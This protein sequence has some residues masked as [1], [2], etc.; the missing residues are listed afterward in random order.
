MEV[1]RVAV[2]FGG[3]SMAWIGILD[4]QCN[5]IKSIASFGKGA[6]YLEGLQ[7]PLDVDD[8]LGLGACASA[9]R[10]NRPIWYQ[11]F[12]H[13]PV[14]TQWQEHAARF[15]WVACASLPLHRNGAVAGVFTLYI[16][17]IGAF[18][19]K[20]RDL[21]EEM[22]S[23]IDFALQNFEREAKRVQTENDLRMSEK[24][25][26]TIL[27]M[28]SDG[29]HILDNSGLLVDAN[30]AFLNML[31]YD[32]SAIGKLRVTDWDVQTSSGGI[33][34]TFNNL[35]ANNNSQVLFETRHRRRDGTMLDIE[36]SATAMEIEG[37][38]YIYASSRD[39]SERKQLETEKE[40]YFKFFNTSTDLMCIAD[41][42]G[43]Y[44]K[45]NAAFIQTLGYSE[46]ELLSKPFNDSVH[47][48][49][50]QPTLDSMR[51]QRER[52]YTHD[53]E[54]RYRCKDGTYK[55]LSWSVG[56]D[57]DEGINYAVYAVAH[58]ITERKQAE[59]QLRKLSMAVEQSPESIVI[60][61]LNAEI[62]YVNDAFVKIT[63]YSR[64]ESIGQNPRFLSSG[65]TPPE[66]FK[67]L[68]DSLSKGLSWDG[69]FHN[70][71]K[72][73]SEYIEHAIITPIRQ[74]DESITHY[75][76]V[77]EDITDKKVASDMI[78]TL[79]FYDTLTGLPNRR[80][81]LDRLNHA[82][83]AGSRS[84]RIGALLFIDLDNFKTLNDTLGH[85][86][87]DLLL[88]QVAQRLTSCVREGDTVAR[89]GGDE[90]VVILEN[91]SEIS[92]EAT[93]QAE[94]VGEKIMAS[95]NQTYQL[96]N[97]H[98]RST[99]SIGIAFFSGQQQSVEDLLKQADLAMYQAKAAGR[100]TLSLF[101]PEMQ[102]LISSRA[103]LEEDLR[104]AVLKNQFVLHYQPQ[105]VGEGSLTGVEV[106]LRWRHP[107]RGM[108]SP[109]EFIPLAE[110]TG[111]ILPIGHWVLKTACNQLAKWADMPE[112]AHL[113]I[114]VNVSARQFGQPTFV[115]EVLA[116]ME[117]CGANPAKLK[118]ELTESILLNDVESVITKMSALKMK[119]VGFSLDD[120]GTG[121][122]SLSYLK[123]LPLDQLK[124]DRGFVRGT[125]TDPEDAAIA[126][127]VV[128]LAESMGL[129]VI[130]EGV[131]IE[132]QRDFLAR[133]GCH[134]Y[135]GY[136]FSRPI[137]LEEFEDYVKMVK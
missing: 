112:M 41:H 17:V 97:Y 120:F 70:L 42:N 10:E 137:P 39:I 94:V 61:N 105:V 80:L 18:D 34:E 77:K 134:A 69:L 126:K 82:L 2:T 128:V 24:R 50:L 131:E 75:V 16:D 46:I 117:H 26:R 21:L 73:G 99:P 68:W 25:L 100:N 20:A 72:D 45:V 111:L 108:V 32:K 83:A 101:N 5:Q 12:Q 19:D 59:L 27:R 123:R 63:G 115:D 92:E 60:T 28:A 44:K 52:G 133:H 76:A 40:L 114:A 43:Y 84:K 49:D 33:K 48:D 98:H 53:F 122:S 102:T 104:E 51:E 54:N 135:Q 110:E 96:G 57:K 113:T 109:G 35:I 78:N 106:L 11:D 38:N 3:M 23:D 90:F 86:V 88:Q 31:G 15:G 37:Q 136:L 67:S 6:E 95:L 55:W 47:P 64:E 30:D 91:L 22:T 29:I 56:I 87:G 79:A 7:I 1:C 129:S 4:E 107:Q 116:I 124:I 85:D 14:P 93:A 125:L 8:P 62:E 127:M 81:L 9:F 66:N 121:Y 13:T 71:R 130:A 132:A 65:K 58:D 118:L 89:F 119:G 74:A 36:I 103:R